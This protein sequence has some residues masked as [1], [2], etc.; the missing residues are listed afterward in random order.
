MAL[1]NIQQTTLN[2]SGASGTYSVSHDAGSNPT[3]V[4][5]AIAG[6]TQNFTASSVTYGGSALTLQESRRY[7]WIGGYGDTKSQVWYRINTGIPSGSNTFAV[8]HSGISVGRAIIYTGR[9]VGV[10][11]LADSG[12]EYGLNKTHGDIS[13]SA[14]TLTGNAFFSIGSNSGGFGAGPYYLSYRDVTFTV[15]GNSRGYIGHEPS[16]DAGTR[17]VGLAGSIQTAGNITAL[18]LTDSKDGEVASP[19]TVGSGYKSLVLGSSPL[20]YWRLHEGSGSY[21]DIV[22]GLDGTGNGTI[23][24]EVTGNFTWES[25]LQKNLGIGLST[26][27][28]YVDIGDNHDFTAAASYSVMA[29]VAPFANQGTGDHYVVQKLDAN[30]YGYCLGVQ[31]SDDSP[32]DALFALRA[33]ASGTDRLEGGVVSPYDNQWYCAIVTFDETTGEHRL[34]FNGTMVAA[35][36]SS[37]TDLPDHTSNFTI[38]SA[39]AAR[40]FNGG[41]DEVA[42]WSRA[43][44]EREV[45]ELWYLGSTQQ[46][47]KEKE[48]Y[49]DLMNIHLPAYYYRL[50][51]PYRATGDRVGD[52]IAERNL[53][54]GMPWGQGGGYQSLGYNWA[55]VSATTTL[56]LVPNGTFDSSYNGWTAS[57]VDSTS[58]QS[59]G[60]SGGYL[61]LVGD[62]TGTEAVTNDITVP[63]GVHIVYRISARLYSTVIDN[64]V[65]ELVR[66]DESGAEVESVS[67]TGPSTPSTWETVTAYTT[68]DAD[69]TGSIGFRCSVPDGSTATS[70][71]DD[72]LVLPA[73]GRYE[74]G[75][76]GATQDRYAA[77]ARLEYGPLEG[78]TFA[79]AS[80]APRIIAS[81]PTGSL[82]EF[83]HNKWPWSLSLWVKVNATNPT[84]GGTVT[85][86]WSSDTTEGGG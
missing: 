86:L 8:T 6:G 34:Y 57:D 74:R 58:W 59:D 69:Q 46:R 25:A 81:S 70:R 33:S 47:A 75:V 12:E 60:A 38:G 51:E 28:G 54:Q 41:V 17:L 83:L 16:G 2:I 44:T 73:R 80:D 23:T 68:Q 24:R 29:W 21:V 36:V 9:S 85:S 71:F 14:G 82:N 62:G 31:G 7:G 15:D 35:S 37:I 66:Y 26:S 49:R 32:A 52:L 42:V 18:M 22:G 39:T 43:L 1:F 56:N 48:S 45:W 61:Q 72:L 4:V 27:A 65:F 53:D 11:A 10:V 76:D 20:S 5:V 64:A 78:D 19:P 63:S 67:I 50:N 55:P 30:P 40:N 13:L 77:A 84:G 3:W 79:D